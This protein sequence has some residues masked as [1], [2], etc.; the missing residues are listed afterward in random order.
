MDTQNGPDEFE[1]RI[2]RTQSLLQSAG[3]SRML[4]IRLTAIEGQQAGPL[5]CYLRAVHLAQLHP[6]S[7]VLQR[8]LA[9]CRRSARS[10]LAKYAPPNLADGWT[11]DELPD[12]IEAISLQTPIAAP[13]A[14]TVPAATPPFIST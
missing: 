8:K 11:V 13:S 12:K 14:D 1:Q 9:E 7:S 4:S 5:R 10:V 3:F 2:G 6:H